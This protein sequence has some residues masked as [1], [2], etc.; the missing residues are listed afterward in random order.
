M[1]LRVQMWSANDKYE[2]F[3][4]S[5]FELKGINFTLILGESISLTGGHDS[6]TCHNGTDFVFDQSQGTGWW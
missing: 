2:E 5:H 6:L 4:Y 1:K 3:V